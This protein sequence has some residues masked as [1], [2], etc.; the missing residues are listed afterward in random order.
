[1]PCTVEKVS[2]CVLMDPSS[3]PTA[4]ALCPGRA[5]AHHTHEPRSHNVVSTVPSFE[6]SRAVLSVP[7]TTT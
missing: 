4:M 1:M 5:R 2:A 6:H 7:P 3:D